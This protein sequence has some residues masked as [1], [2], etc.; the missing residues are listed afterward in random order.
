MNI[1]TQIKE[2]IGQEKKILPNPWLS[3]RI[4]SKIDNPIQKQIPYWQPAFF[5]LA[6]VLTVL[7]GIRIGIAFTPANEMNADVVLNDRDIECLNYY[8]LNEDE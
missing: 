5:S 8:N 2:Y 4:M 7:L 3:A 6:I 1:P